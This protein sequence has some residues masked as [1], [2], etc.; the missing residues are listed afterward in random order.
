MGHDVL[1]NFEIVVA[2]NLN[3]NSRYQNCLH[4]TN[5]VTSMQ[6]LNFLPTITEPRRF[7]SNERSGYQQLLDHIW[8]NL[9]CSYSTGH[10]YM[11]ITDH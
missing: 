5:F 2:V 7:L 6:S 1:S 11:N 8:I 4:V 10:Y 3:I 9:I